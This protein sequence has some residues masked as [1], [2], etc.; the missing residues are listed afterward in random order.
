[1]EVLNALLNISQNYSRWRVEPSYTAHKPGTGCFNKAPLRYG[2]IDDD[3]QNELALFLNEEL[4]V[5]S[6][7]RGR[8]VFA[9]FIDA[10]DWFRQ[11]YEPSEAEDGKTYQAVS[12]TLAIN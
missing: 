11:E 2:D 9:A 12:E 7:Q 8:T 4:I 5:F 3:S 10:S 1:P 6:P